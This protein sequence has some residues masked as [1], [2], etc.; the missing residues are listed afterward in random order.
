MNN[1]LSLT[2]R[3][4]RNAILNKVERKSDYDSL[5]ELHKNYWV[6]QGADYFAANDDS[7]KNHFLVDCAF[8]F[9]LLKEELRKRPDEFTQLVEIGTGSGRALEFLSSKFPEISSFIGV[10][11]SEAQVALN[12]EK[13]KEDKKLKFV[14][15]DGFEWV[16]N[17]GRSHTIFVT[18]RGVLEYF[19]EEQLQRCLKQVNKLGKI[20]FVAIEPKGIDHN[21]EDNPNSQPYGHERSFSHNYP[22]LFKNA[23]FNLWHLSDKP[24]IKDSH[25]LLFIGASNDLES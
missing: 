9:D 4:M 15:S 13:F 1:K 23:G 21:F 11:L 6:N 24:C 17:Y 8:I 20:I 25:D 10:D 3:L 7:F 16:K 19:T 14:A 22:Q 2:E 12:N 18:S 5:A